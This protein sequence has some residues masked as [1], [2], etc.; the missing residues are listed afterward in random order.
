MN[1]KFKKSYI[2]SPTL[3]RLLHHATNIPTSQF[4]EQAN[5]AVIIKLSN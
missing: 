5:M 1:C 4:K 3:Q 2:L